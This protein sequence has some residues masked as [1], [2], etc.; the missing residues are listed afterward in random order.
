VEHRRIPCFGILSLAVAA[1]V[2]PACGGGSSKPESVSVTVTAAAGGTLSL[3]GGPTITIPA[4]ALTSDTVITITDTGS[5]PANALTRVYEF[6]PSGL[7]LSKPLKVSIPIPSMMRAATIY[8]T[9]QGSTSE[10]EGLPTTVTGAMASAEVTHFSRAYAAFYSPSDLAGTWDA[11]MF[12]TS[13]D[14][15]VLSGLVDI[16]SQGETSRPTGSYFG[17]ASGTWS[18]DAAGTI[19]NIGPYAFP[20]T[21]NFLASSKDLIIGTHSQS[22]PPFPTVNRNL[23]VYRK[24]KAGAWASAAVG[25]LSFAYLTLDPLHPEKS[26]QS[27]V[28]STDQYG[29]VTLDGAQLQLS[30]D[31]NGVVQSSL[32]S[33]RGFMTADGRNIFLASPQLGLIILMVTGQ[34]CTQGDLTGP[35]RY[36]VITNGVDGDSSPW[37]YGD[38]TFDGSGAM[39]PLS[40]VT[41]GGPQTF[42]GFT[43][44]LDVA[45][46][47]SRVDL[48]SY[49]GHLSHNKD[50]YVRVQT[51]GGA[52]SLSIMTY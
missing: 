48:P 47:G 24:R 27:G 28:S 19:T 5:S 36:R 17:F 9:K 6:G 13:G 50:L 11:V 43:V 38:L 37:M 20:T 44:K 16:D 4:G 39:T 32:D 22:S 14:A 1:Y 42:P 35:W 7:T 25:N 29:A 49:F 15:K 33:T 31:E 40:A 52:N 3:P 23:A 46:N 41:P 2:L 45:C 30:V 51:N 21:N 12:M 8:W 10:Y 34:T 18:I 26:W